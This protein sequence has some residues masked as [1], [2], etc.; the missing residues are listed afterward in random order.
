MLGKT[1]HEYWESQIENEAYRN[2]AAMKRKMREAEE[3][4]IPLDVLT[5]ALKEA[6]Y[7]YLNKK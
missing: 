6:I 4:N 3:E 1:R 2:Y 5:A 7:E